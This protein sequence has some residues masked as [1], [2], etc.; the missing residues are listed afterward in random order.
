MEINFPDQNEY[1]RDINYM[2]KNTLN[3]WLITACNLDKVNPE[4]AL[5]NLRNKFLY[6]LTNYKILRIIIK[7]Q[8]EK[9]KWYYVNNSDLIFDNL[10]SIINPPKDDSPKNY[11]TEPLPLWR[12]T[13]YSQNN[14][15]NLRLDINHAI[16]DGRVIFDYLELFASIANG[17]KIPDKYINIKG[18]QP[19]TPLNIKDY[20]EQNVFENC[21]IPESWK[22]AEVFKL[23]PEVKLPSYSVC[24][25][26][27]LDYEPFKKFCI[28]YNFTLQG[29]ISA[30]YTRAIWN[31][32]KGKLDN[33]EIGVYT[34]IDIRKLKYTKEKIKQG[35]FQYN[36]SCVIPFVKKMS[37]ILE[38]IKHCQEEFKK[39]YNSLE[40]YHAFITLFNLM[41]LETQK[42]DYIKEFPDNSSKNIIFSSHIGR[43]PERKNIKFGL[44]MPVLDWGYWPDLYAFHNSTTVYFVFERP[45]NVDKN[46][47]DSL[48]DSILEIYDFIKQNI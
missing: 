44:T 42:I 9:L 21:A 7:N 12:I 17:D 30:A 1:I 47:V 37:N 34:P 19:L 6:L 20:F 24:D 3:C 16:T 18:Y 32:H 2:E 31:Y 39:C 43:V 28:K 46:Y 14:E 41:N 48:H 35:I 8:N 22:R 25:N 33:M 40:G 45:F 4:Q 10:I 26:W 13:I 27:E 38:Q 23:N 11:P 36:V 15:T 5:N 29:I